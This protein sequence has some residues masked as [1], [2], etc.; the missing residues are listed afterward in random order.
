MQPAGAAARPAPRT[1]SCCGCRTPEWGSV[2]QA[3]APPQPDRAAS[4]GPCPASQRLPGTA[5][6]A[7][8]RSPVTPLP[9]LKSTPARVRQAGPSSCDEARLVL[10]VPGRAEQV[11]TANRWF[12]QR[13]QGRL[14]WPG[15]PRALSW[16]VSAGW[17]PS[18]LRGSRGPPEGL[19]PA[20]EGRPRG[21]GWGRSVHSSAANAAA[22]HARSKEDARGVM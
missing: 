5:R 18:K 13:H 14:A 3:G 6:V 21:R 7:S 2:L 20:G 9:A 1:A 16:V 8:P 17:G 4:L 12:P 22:S 11:V 10:C 19:W 15:P